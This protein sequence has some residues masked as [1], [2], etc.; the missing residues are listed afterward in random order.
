M[1]ASVPSEQS[2]P[3]G[4]AVSLSPVP[5]AVPEGVPCLLPAEHRSWRL[6]LPCCSS[7]SWGLSVVRP[8]ESAASQNLLVRS[9]AGGERG[10]ITGTL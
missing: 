5:I 4:R 2:D 9:G 8:R 7:C 6:A 10:L 3:E 1:G